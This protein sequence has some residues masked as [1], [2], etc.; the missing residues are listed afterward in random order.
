MRLRKLPAL[1]IAGLLVVALMLFLRDT[2]WDRGVGY[3]MGALPYLLF[4]IA[5]PLIL[6]VLLRF[7]YR[8]FARPYLRF[9]RMRRYLNNKELHEAARRGR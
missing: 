8:M 3:V 9:L 1:G 2:S 4:I 6:Y 7:A 5:L